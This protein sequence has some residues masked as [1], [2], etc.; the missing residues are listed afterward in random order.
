MKLI[1]VTLKKLISISDPKLLKKVIINAHTSLSYE[2]AKVLYK[3]RIDNLMKEYKEVF[4]N[5]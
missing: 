2:P 3:K 4:Q 1:R 5:V